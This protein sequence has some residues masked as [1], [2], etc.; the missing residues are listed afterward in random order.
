MNKVFFNVVGK[1]KFDSG[2]ELLTASIV[3]DNESLADLIKTYELPMATKEGNPDL[4]GDYGAIEIGYSSVEKYYLGLE[5]AGW[6]DDQDKTILLGCVCG[7][8]GCWP[9][10]C[11]IT[12]E[13]DKVVW[14]DF[15]QPHRDE[16]WDYTDFSG[17][18]FDKQQYKNAIEAMK[19][20]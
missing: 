4:A 7:V 10:L 18:V 2:Y 13:G 15:E 9:L 11:K 16:D 20:G 12:V 6:G 1:Q 3:V 8:A 19:S 14:S 17:F 5:E